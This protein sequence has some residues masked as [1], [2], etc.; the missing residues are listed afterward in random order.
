LVHLADEP[1]P[2]RRTA[3]LGGRLGR[4]VRCLRLRRKDLTRLA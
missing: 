4:D 2:A 1:C 3:P